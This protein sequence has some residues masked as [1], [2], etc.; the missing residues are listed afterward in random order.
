MASMNRIGESSKGQS[1][2][3]RKTAEVSVAKKSPEKQHV[4]VLLSLQKFLVL[5]CSLLCKLFETRSIEVEK[6]EASINI[7]LPHSFNVSKN[8]GWLNIN[9]NNP[10]S[11]LFIFSGLII[12][13][14]LE[15]AKLPHLG[16]ILI[17]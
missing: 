16:Q 15:V 9:S 12:E 5:F 11:I 2:W 6:I 14:Y 17:V 10:D 4:T 7:A 13:F 8:M 3:V 1:K